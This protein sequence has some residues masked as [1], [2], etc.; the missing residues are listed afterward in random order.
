[1]ERN[2]EA[3][4]ITAVPTEIDAL[5]KLATLEAGHN[6]LDCAELISRI[7]TATCTST[8]SLQTSERVYLLNL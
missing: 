7:S 1:M 2:I 8:H 6:Y 4:Y 5:G 3:N